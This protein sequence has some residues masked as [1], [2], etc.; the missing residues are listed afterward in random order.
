[1]RSLQQM[2]PT[3]VGICHHV[4][5]ELDRHGAHHKLNQ[6]SPFEEEQGGNNSDFEACR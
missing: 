5:D 4:D 1:M 3:E 2:S 6:R